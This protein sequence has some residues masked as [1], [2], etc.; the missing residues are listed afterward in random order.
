MSW[1]SVP[2]EVLKTRIDKQ[3]A[4]TNISSQTFIGFHCVDEPAQ[5]RVSI[6]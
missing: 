2:A 3:L 1:D 6:Y 4:E 5:K